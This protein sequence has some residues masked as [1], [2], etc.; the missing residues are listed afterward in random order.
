MKEIPKI[1]HYCWFGKKEIPRKEA[2][3]IASWKKFFPDYELRLWNEDNIGLEQ[4]AYAKQAYEQG[5]F[6]FVS[7]YVRAKVLYEYGGIYLDA[8]VKVLKEFPKIYVEAGFLGFERRAFLG[9]A[10]MG[11]HP[12]NEILKELKDYYETHNFL[13]EKGRM[14]NIANVS[15]LTDIMKKKGLVLGGE[16]QEIEGF[17]IFPREM[18]YPKKLSETEFRITEETCCVHLCSNSW[19]TEREKRR[20][21]NKIWIEIVRPFLREIRKVGIKILGKEKIRGVEIW[22]RDK[23]R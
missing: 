10:V 15:V 14:D 5:L 13:N 6:A 9:T 7:D 22:I 18:F 1:I 20:G 19:M 3:C 16:P 11:C 17:K 8:D 23:M 12:G 21:K 4:C 2:E